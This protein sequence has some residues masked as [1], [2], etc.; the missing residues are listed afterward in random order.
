V[1]RLYRPV[2]SLFDLQVTFTRSL[3]L[4]V[5][6]FD[7]LDRDNPIVSP[8]NGVKPDVE[9]QPIEY[10][11]VAFGYEEGQDIL[12][13]VNFTVPGGA[14]MGLPS[15]VVRGVP[16]GSVTGSSGSPEGVA[17]GMGVKCPPPLPV[18]SSLLSPALTFT[19]LLWT[20]VPGLPP[21]NV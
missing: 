1:N 12:T 3:A 17:G 9:R 6:V 21:S 10:E 16:S 5:R 7:Y 13:D 11:H 8:D 18:L 15:G 2:E 14:M 20:G 19:G 4:F